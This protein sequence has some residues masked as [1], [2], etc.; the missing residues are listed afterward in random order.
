VSASAPRRAR[1]YVNETSGV[2]EEGVQESGERDVEKDARWLC[3]AM[4]S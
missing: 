3:Q 4:R 1:A 2:G